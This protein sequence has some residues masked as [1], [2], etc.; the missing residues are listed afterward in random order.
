MDL[1]N[2]NGTWYFSEIFR[3]IFKVLYPSGRVFIF[4]F[5]C[6]S[7]KLLASSSP[8]FLLWLWVLNEVAI[9]SPKPDKQ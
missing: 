1:A 6:V 5:I 9:R 8:S 3:I 4:S 7:V 2:G